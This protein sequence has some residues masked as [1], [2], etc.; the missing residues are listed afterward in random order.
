M[1][2]SG[3]SLEKV[4]ADLAAGKQIKNLNQEA[5]RYAE[6]EKRFR[7]TSPLGLGA[8]ASPLLRRSPSGLGRSPSRLSISQ[9]DARLYQARAFSPSSAL[10]AGTTRDSVRTSV[11]GTAF[12]TNYVRALT[13][14]TS[15]SP[16]RGA[17]GRHS[18]RGLGDAS[19]E[20]R[21]YREQKNLIL[22]NLRNAL[23]E[24]AQF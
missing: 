15:R 4:V 13:A 9:L 22:A 12:N 2:K 19:P 17:L 3:E 1:I 24:Q 18:A 14:S 11:H 7:R 5:Q 8:G 6:A 21:R 20:A 10:R 16:V 23:G